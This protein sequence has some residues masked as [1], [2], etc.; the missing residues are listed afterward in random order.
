MVRGF[1]NGESD[2]TGLGRE[3]TL[4]ALGRGEKVIATARSRSINKLD[5]LK[6]Q[7][8]QLVELDVTTSLEQLKEIANRSVEIYGHV[9]ILVNN[10]GGCLSFIHCI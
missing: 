6:A 5:D 3:L 10:A 8:A 4:A 7:G 2:T 1:C 9:D